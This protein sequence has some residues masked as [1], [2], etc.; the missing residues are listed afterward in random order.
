MS[1]YKNKDDI[2]LL[3]LLKKHKPLIRSAAYDAYAG[4]FIRFFLDCTN[5]QLSFEE[6]VNIYNESF[7]ALNE[8]ILEGAISIPLKMSILQYLLGIGSQCIQS[9]QLHHPLTNFDKHLAGIS[10]YAAGDVLLAMAVQLGEKDHTIFNTIYEVYQEDANNLVNSKGSLKNQEA[11]DYFS[12]AM[13]KLKSNIDNKKVNPPLSTTLFNYFILIFWRLTRDKEKLKPKKDIAK[14]EDFPDN[15]KDTL[16][17]EITSLLDHENVRTDDEEG[18]DLIDFLIQFSKRFDF[19]SKELLFE[20]LIA[21]L[22]DVTKEIFRYYYIEE[23]TFK[24]IA[25]KLGSPH[26]EG[27][28]KTAHHRGLNKLREIFGIH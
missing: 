12:D 15:N 25:I 22:N 16:P 19:D 3:S 1:K 20:E 6:C 11:N 27:S 10:K 5:N 8:Q 7:A 4:I 21:P 18:N 9:K 2:V 17:I 26:T 13:L 28:C 23:M 24:E 14:E